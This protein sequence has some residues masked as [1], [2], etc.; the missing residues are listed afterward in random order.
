MKVT[1]EGSVRVDL[2]GGT[3]DLQPIALIL[4]DVVTINMATGLK[5]KV[6][7]ETLQDNSFKI[8]SADY[9]KEYHYVESD[10]KEE[11][12][13]DAGSL[14]P[15]FFKEM[16]FII[17]LCKSF[18][19]TRG[20][21]ISLSSGAPT[22]SGLGG[23]S[24]MGI[25]L[26]EAIL[27]LKG[28]SMQQSSIIEHVRKV[29][30]LMLDRGVAGYQDYYPALY[31]GILSLTPGIT[32]HKVEQCYTAELANF[33]EKNIVLVYSGQTRNS[34]I[35]NWEVFKNFFDNKNA[36]GAKNTRKGLIEIAK[37]AQKAYVAIKSKNYEDFLTLIAQEGQ[38]REQLFPGIMTQE[39]KVVDQQCRKVI[40]N[41]KGIK[42]CGAGGGG[43]F[44][45]VGT[46]I[47]EVEK[48]VADNKMQILP[49]KIDLPLA[50]K[51]RS[52]LSKE[53]LS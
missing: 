4:K 30:E 37:I 21:K 26:V 16:L 51:S 31:G 19:L 27:A 7:I 24:A 38:A 17:L 46:K 45:M 2:V 1:T 42:V 48:I 33:I 40:K 13:Y 12:L 28:K 49:L 8:F 44:I 53:H 3:L 36:E 15:H 14:S 35:N 11:N 39:M 22:G 29:E 10:F 52:I 6:E 47:S 25:T 50:A 18:N 43:C 23:S 34:G 20:V 5:A 9:N 32:E 41:Y